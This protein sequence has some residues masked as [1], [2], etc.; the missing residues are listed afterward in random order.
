MRWW[1]VFLSVLAPVAA[2]ALPNQFAQEGILLDANG[3]PLEGARTVRVRLYAAAMGGAPVF[4]ERHVGVQLFEGYYSVAVGS[5]VA[6]D[7]A[8]FASPQLYLAISI[9][10]GPDLAP[11][12]PLRKVPAAMHADIAVNAT[13]DIT[14]RSVAIAGVG[15]VIN[16]Q[17]RWVGNPTGLQ[18]PMG[19]AGPAGPQ[20]PAGPAGPAGGNGSPD[21][22]EQV[23]AKLLQVDGAG[24]G[25]D[26]D[27]LDGLSSDRFMRTDQNTGTVGNLSAGG[28]VSGAT[29]SVTGISQLGDDLRL[30]DDP[31]TGVD[32]LSFNDPGPDGA[33]TWTGSQAQIYVA[34]LDNSNADGYLRLRND[35]GISLESAV[36]V[37]GQLDLTGAARLRQG[38]TVDGG[39]TFNDGA[40]AMRVVASGDGGRALVHAA[41]DV[42]IVNAEGEFAGGTRLEGQVTAA[43]DLTVQRDL[44]VNRHAYVV[45]QI[46]PSVGS[47][48]NGL[49]WPSPGGGD[50]AWVQFHDVAG[51]DRVLRLGV[52]NDPGDRIE[53]Y[54]PGRVWLDGP[55]AGP[56][57]FEFPKDRWGG[58]G[59]S[60]WIRYLGVAGEDTR[61][62]IGINN[63]AGD[64]IELYSN[65][66]TRLTGNGSEAIGLLFQANRWGGSGDDAYIRYRSEAGENTVLEIGVGDNADDNLVLRASG[67]VSVEGAFTVDGASRQ[68]GVAVFD[69]E[70]QA[71][72]GLAVREGQALRFWTDSNNSDAVY[73]RNVYE[74]GDITNLRLYVH[75]NGGRNDRFSIWGDSCGGGGCNN[76]ALAS[77][78]HRFWANG[79][80]D[81]V[82]NV[83]VG[84]SLTVQ[85]ASTFRGTPTFEAFS[86]NFLGADFNIRYA[87]RGDGGRA[88]VHD[89]GD[90]LALNYAGDFAGGT[91]IDGNASVGGNLNIGGRITGDCPTNARALY[92]ICIWH[93]GGY[94]KLYREAAAQC[95]DGGGHICSLEEVYAAWGAGYQEC[96]CGWTSTANGPQ[97]DNGSLRFHAVYPMQAGGSGGCGGPVP[98]VRLCGLDLPNNGLT[99]WGSR[100]WGA[101]C[102]K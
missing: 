67:G 6:L 5:L 31:I 90:T 64:Q 76:E 18:G 86:F 2:Q 40:V 101:Y 51:D 92:G 28:Q 7:P 27:L 57:G 63:D 32:G 36:R 81:H 79:D 48:A 80:A 71:R 41:G 61:L 98:G 17:G 99:G 9:D 83:F 68:T 65:S 69:G 93:I 49:V 14:P 4:E 62:Q 34:P 26:A 33:I 42:L 94:D 87:P 35:G 12:T 96:S 74:A 10:D 8:L 72:G 23:R 53:L 24:T 58:S 19:P 25:I 50:V 46:Q 88:I 52:N 56:F 29:L 47:G 55:G 13:G 102:C 45:G 21:T 22:P 54:S 100:G 20:G 16:A 82:G 95:R 73:F 89:G 39:A 1:W 75:D 78:K 60:A 3:D 66:M 70:V 44:R 30:S 97:Y 43:L 37:D 59:D 85:G 91:R 38:I 11:R 84:G 15:Q 77:E